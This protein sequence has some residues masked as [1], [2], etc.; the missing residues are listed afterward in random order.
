MMEK[1]NSIAYEA[2]SENELRKFDEFITNHISTTEEIYDAESIYARTPEAEAYICGSDQIWGGSWPYYLSFAP[3]ST[4]KIAYAPS[5]GGIQRFAPEYEDRLRQLLK[6]FDL[7]GMREESGVLV[8]ERLGRPDAVQVVDPTLL[9]TQESYDPLRIKT[10]HAGEYLFLYLLGNP[11]SRDVRDFYSFAASKG[12]QVIYVASQGRRDHFAKTPAQIGE[13]VDMLANAKY[14]IT[15]SYHCTVFSLIYRKKFIV[16]PLDKGY[17]RMNT[18]I[19][20][21]LSKCDLTSRILLNQKL[22]AIE[23]DISFSKFTHYQQEETKK[24]RSLL[25]TALKQKCQN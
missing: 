10:Q 13:W 8:C 2:Q 19:E 7:I 11:I 16:V 5:F 25:I 3:D 24:S 22:S 14:V 12:L 17:A 21:L 20:E 9:L 23:E 18:R 4:T 15:N 1:R 6:R